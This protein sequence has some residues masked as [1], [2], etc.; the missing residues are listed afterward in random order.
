MLF[1]H[2]NTT[3]RK[4]L[5]TQLGTNASIEGAGDLRDFMKSTLL[6]EG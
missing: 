1:S 3:D 5:A 2:E 4:S 6:E